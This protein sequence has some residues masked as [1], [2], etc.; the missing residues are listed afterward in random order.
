MTSCLFTAVVG[1]GYQDNATKTLVLLKAFRIR[2]CLSVKHTVWGKG[3]ALYILSW[4][5]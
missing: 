2:K 3:F 5:R 1:T 4:C